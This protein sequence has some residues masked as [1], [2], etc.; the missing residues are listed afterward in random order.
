LPR[1][2]RNNQFSGLQAA[3]HNSMQYVSHTFMCESW[4]SR[5]GVYSVGR[6]LRCSI[7]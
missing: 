3:R 6:L 2:S 4:D 7:L 1:D 5:A